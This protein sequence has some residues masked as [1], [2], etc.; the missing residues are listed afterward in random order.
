MLAYI[1]WHSRDPHVDKHTYEQR[2]IDFHQLLQ[3]R[4]PGGFLYSAVYQ[5]AGV[6][7]IADGAEAYE[8]WYL[9]ENS[10]A[11]DV[12]NDAAVD[13]QRK[14]THDLVAHDA[15]KGVGGLYRLHS[16]DADLAK[17]RV[18]IWFAK[19]AGTSYETLYATLDPQVQQA[20]AS[21]WRRQM[22]LGPAHEFC[23]HGSE[24]SFLPANFDGL[25][26]PLALLW[27]GR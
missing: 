16:G 6:P 21:L 14:S 4:K 17:A 11:L 18:A 3:E 27:R 15:M 1:F 12:L 26:I 24:N 25:R 5:I 7:W 13:A 9:V 8:D 22:V 19:P 10:A 23:W 2:L 20:G